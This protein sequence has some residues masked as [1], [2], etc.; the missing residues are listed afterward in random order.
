MKDIEIDIGKILRD[1]FH[2]RGLKQKE[3]A[4]KI[5]ENYKSLNAWVSG[6]TIPPGDK[7]LRMIIVLDL[8]DDFFPKYRKKYDDEE[9]GSFEEQ[10]AL[11]SERLKLLEE[12]SA[13]D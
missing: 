11:L 4:E 6:R 13:K 5:G 12:A 2:Q 10:L 7:L 8:V 1:S 3:V 9:L